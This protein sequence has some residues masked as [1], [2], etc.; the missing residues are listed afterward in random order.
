MHVG[1]VTFDAAVQFYSL[2][3]DQAAFQMLVMPDSELPYCPASASSLIVPLS[4]SRE[5]VSTA[6][7]V[8]LTCGS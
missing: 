5:L 1:I 3:P 7:P 6:L 8:D 4:Q 2:R